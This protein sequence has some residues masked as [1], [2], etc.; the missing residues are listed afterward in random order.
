MSACPD[1]DGASIN[2]AF[3]GSGDCQ[4]CHGT[5]EGDM[6]DKIVAGLANS[7]VRPCGMC[8]G[9]GQCQT[10][11]GTG[12]VSASE[13]ASCGSEEHASDDC[14]QSECASSGSNDHATHYDSDSSYS[15]SSSAISPD[16]PST[17]GSKSSSGV[18]WGVFSVAVILAL[19]GIA[20]HFL[21]ERHA[22]NL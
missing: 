22:V 18:F 4:Y 19:L 9:T 1:C 6:L 10:C 20:R 2:L 17:G 15:P 11:G 14:P 5:G 21:K 13:C 16:S 7:E 12:E 3:V 8:A